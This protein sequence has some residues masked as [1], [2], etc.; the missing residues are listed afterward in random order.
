MG[1]KWM[2]FD[3]L[4]FP[5]R[6]PECGGRRFRVVG[7]RKVFSEA[8]YEV[9][10]EDDIDHVEDEITGCDWEEVYGVECVGCGEDLSDEV[11]F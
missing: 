2:Y 6:C 8:V 9:R 1:R 7:A 3:E 4:V 10:G 5:D 11:G